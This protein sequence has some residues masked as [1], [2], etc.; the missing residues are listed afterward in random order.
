MDHR[1]KAMELP[2]LSGTVRVVV[3]LAPDDENP[4][5]PLTVDELASTPTT[6]VLHH[7]QV[8]FLIFFFKILTFLGPKWTCPEK[9]LPDIV[10]ECA[11]VLKVHVLKR[12]HFMQTSLLLS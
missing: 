4:P 10:F 5:V 7:S 2:V 11:Y 12:Q 9:Y 6:S 3:E 8:L 1:E